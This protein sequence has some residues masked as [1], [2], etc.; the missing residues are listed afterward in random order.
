M[1][2]MLFKVI[3]CTASNDIISSDFMT[4]RVHCV[5]NIK[6]RFSGVFPFKMHFKNTIGLRVY[7]LKYST[8]EHTDCYICSQCFTRLQRQ[9]RA[10]LFFH[11]SNN[12]LLN[13]FYVSGIVLGTE[14]LDR[15][16]GVTKTKTRVGERHL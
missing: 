5:R 10:F 9:K 2:M 3:G 8:R 13:D 7:S 16:P 1:L 14:G 11:S 12:Y 4:Q 15:G 6:W